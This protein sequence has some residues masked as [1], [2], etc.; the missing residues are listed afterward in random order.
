M[1]GWRSAWP[2]LCATLIGVGLGRFAYTPLIPF[3]VGVGIVST[4]E[5]AYAGAA[6]LGGYLFGA[7]VAPAIGRQLGTAAAIRIALVGSV[8]SLAAC[9]LP[10]GYAWLLAWR[11]VI[12]VTGAVLLILGPSVVIG[13]AAPAERG[14]AGGLVYTGVG[15]GTM[16]ASAIVAPVADAFTPAA[17]WAALALAGAAATA[18]SWRRWGRLAS[19]R[20][21]AASPRS[22]APSRSAGWGGL[23]TA[24]LLTIA[25]NGMDGAGFVPHT[26]FWVDYIA[27]ALGLGTAAGALNWALFGLGALAGPLLAGAL[28]DRIGLARAAVLAF[29]CKA[30]AVL[31][32]VLTDAPAALALSSAVVGALSPGI[33]SLVGSRLAELVAPARLARAWSFATLSLALGQ[34]AG[35]YGMS[36]ALA[37]SGTYLPLYVAGAAFEAI[38]MILCLAAIAVSRRPRRRAA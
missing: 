26:I 24:A 19:M 3:L 35:A 10:F 8:A 20:G 7:L 38:G 30:A 18:L 22:S 9:A 29:G 15:F 2:G 4:V 17:A 31:L 21:T 11:F 6:N 37:H 25:A 13:L 33:T 34:A 28:G 1:L 32:P 12:G 14:R 27:R 23:P 36:F 16:L 5:A